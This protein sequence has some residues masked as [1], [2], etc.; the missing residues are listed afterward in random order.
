MSKLKQMDGQMK[1]YN[2]GVKYWNTETM[3]HPELTDKE[4]VTMNLILN[5]CW[6]DGTTKMDNSYFNRTLKFKGKD[7]KSVG[8]M[9]GNVISN[10]VKKK[11]IDREFGNFDPL[12]GS[13]ER[14]IWP[15]QK[16]IPEGYSFRE[17]KVIPIGRKR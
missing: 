3:E 5:L 12:K 8:T 15:L 2:K 16:G 10:L 17:I 1:K 11:F 6:R 9:V 4:S 7:A 14:T 13:K